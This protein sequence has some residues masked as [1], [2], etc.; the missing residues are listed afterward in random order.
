[1]D[2]VQTMLDAIAA[3]PADNAAWLALADSLEDAGRFAE[4]E[5]ARLRE[6]LRHA[7][8]DD[9]QRGPNERRMQQLLADG[10][11]PISP[12]M[13]LPLADGVEMEFRLVPPGAFWVG[14]P[15]DEPGR[16]DDEPPREWVDIRRGFWMGTY[17]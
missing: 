1:M 7:A 9:P 6:W 15:P 12:V 14:S 16:A 8:L 4:A 11:R 10:V 2:A 17:P 13:R 5:V 3:D